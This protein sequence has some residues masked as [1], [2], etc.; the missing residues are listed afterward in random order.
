MAS[1]SAI[2]NGLKARLA[3]I[4]GLRTH[5]VWPDTL[6]VP[7][8]LVMAPSGTYGVDMG[9][10][11]LVKADIIVIAAP[12]QNGIVRA[13]Q[14]LDAYLASTGAR[15]VRVALL[16]D[17]TLGGIAQTINVMGWRD[18]GAITVNGIEYAGCHVDV[19][20]WVL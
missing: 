6:N 7:A 2:R 12:L 19:E 13:Q 14:Q 4:A 1:V 15:S 10:T 8:A 3:T 11:V 17:R 20:V 9:G 18:Y 16:A 5:D